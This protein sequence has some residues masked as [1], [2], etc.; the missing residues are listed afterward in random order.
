[1]MKTGFKNI[2]GALALVV[3]TAM[4]V[5]CGGGGGGGTSVPSSGGSSGGGGGGSGGSA[6]GWISGV[7]QA[8]SQF[9]D[10]CQSPRSGVDSEGN[11][12]TDKAGTLSDEKNWLRSWTHETYLWNTEVYDTDPGLPGAVL[13]YFGIL[14]TQAKTAS[15][16][17]KDNFH[18]SQ[19]TA[20]YLAQRNSAA[21]ASYG[22]TFTV[23]S[24]TVPRDVRVAF[25]DPGTPADNVV[26]GQKNL[27]R[28]T[29]ILSVNGI[30]LVNGGTTQAQVDQLNQGLFPPTAGT[31]NTF[32]VRDPGSSVTRTITLTSQNLVSKP[33]NR[34]K[35]LTD[36]SGNKVGYILFNTFSPYSSESD[37]VSAISTLRD[38]NV[39]DLVLDL[40]YNG[41][42][43]LAVASELGYMVAGN[44]RT[45]GRTFERLSFN[46]AAGT[47]NPVTGETNSPVPFYNSGQ[48]FSVT[49][50]TALP[51][52]NLGRV[53]VLTTG[54][55]CSASEAVINGLRGAGV[56]VIQIGSKTCG[57]PYGFYPQ[58]N[59]G[60]TYYSI[61]FQGVNDIGFGDYADG[62]VPANST[63]VNGVKVPGCAVADDYSRELGDSAEG[64]LSA[65][66]GYGTAGTCPAVSTIVAKS[67]ASTSGTRVSSPALS[68]PVRF[69]METN[70]DMTHIR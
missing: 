33:V 41:G 28:G 5:S 40:R 22:A 12:F 1:M 37:L 64:L 38:A 23:I 54:S 17:D 10:K 63:E 43:L 18:F 35:V 21:T 16:K 39:S 32:V 6:S 45:T 27:I 47:R 7:F 20:D 30:D 42:G 69:I 49:A 57:K 52:L 19:P 56:Q 53:F 58:D 25:T 31:T 11:A 65:A 59:C 9:K 15:G 14:K 34:T 3:A 46:A 2:A 36:G 61:Q 51:T 4:L 62:F 44:T 48:G 70:R 60:T 55:T 50:G 24:G 13:D 66:L 29:Q 68:P 67:G 26:G 8:A